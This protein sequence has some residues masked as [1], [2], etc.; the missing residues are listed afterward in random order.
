[1]DDEKWYESMRIE[2]EK[3]KIITFIG[4]IVL[5]TFFISGGLLTF[6]GNDVYLLQAAT[7]I[8]IVILTV[9]ILVY[10]IY[11]LIKNRKNKKTKL[12]NKY[13]FSTFFL[14][15]VFIISNYLVYNRIIS[16]N[17][18]TNIILWTYIAL[19]LIYLIWTRKEKLQYKKI[20]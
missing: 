7:F 15:L 12:Y 6:F 18:G 20:L 9:L 11:S 1:M 17:L 14:S 19:G 16:P 2:T 3:D 5:I 10:L 8:V 4:F 13:A